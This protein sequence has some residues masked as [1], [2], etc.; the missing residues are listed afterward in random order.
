MPED[1]LAVA[2][3]SALYLDLMVVFGVA[4]FGVHA[5]RES[6]RRSAMA[7]Q[8]V[9]VIGSAAALGIGLSLASMV[10]MAKAM[11]G[12]SAYAELSAHVF[13]MI[14][15][16][17]AV[18]LA[19]V[20][21]A[22]AL[23]AVLAAVV[24]LSTRPLPRLSVLSA[25]GAV[26]LATLAW[27]G[28]GAMDDGM[29]GVFHLVIDIAHLLAAGAW[30]GALVAFV[31]LASVAKDASPEAADLLG[32]ASNGFAHI[33]TLIVATLVVTGVANYFLIAG[34]TLDGL[35]GTAYGNLL[36]V[37]LALF[38]LMLLLAAA[39]RYRLSPRLAAALC[40]GS[41]AEAVAVLRRSLVM[42]AS[43]AGL[44]LVLVAWLGVLS[45][46]GA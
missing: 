33:G 19:L 24:A 12:A 14:V 23:L 2:L 13:S 30:V 43:L 40:I 46:T 6:D 7:R 34:P 16:G 18:G 28:H 22:V 32:R 11:T 25:I 45:P 10:V 36:L 17:T 44:I 31:M 1:W 20:M 4:L 42:E 27:A 5:M 9:R 41:Y 29:R 21:R 38:A 26:A 3:R 8:Y 39:N 15:T 35:P 37:K